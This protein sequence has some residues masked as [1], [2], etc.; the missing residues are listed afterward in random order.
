MLS[1]PCNFQVAKEGYPTVKKYSPIWVPIV[2]FVVVSVDIINNTYH[3]EIIENIA[4]SY[5]DFVRQYH[6]FDGE[7]LKEKNRIRQTIAAQSQPFTVVVEL[8]SGSSH[9]EENVDGRQSYSDLYQSLK[10]KYSTEGHIRQIM[11]TDNIMNSAEGVS[12][13]QPELENEQKCC[14]HSGTVSMSGHPLQRTLWHN[15]TV[16]SNPSSNSNRVKLNRNHHFSRDMI[17]DSYD[18]ITSLYLSYWNTYKK[19][20]NGQRLVVKEC[21]IPN[22]TQ[23]ENTDTTNNRS[24]PNKA[25]NDRI[26]RMMKINDA[27]MNIRSLQERIF[28]LKQERQQG[29]RD[30]DD[31]EMDIREAQ[32]EIIQLQRTHLNWF[33]YF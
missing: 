32:K 24:T 26:H 1:C 12:E 33:Y 16:S 19:V 6:G 5:V 21:H 14:G 9:V 23:H 25:H 28:Q 13:Q 27:K 10:N 11:F 3:R 17:F 20:E 2:V 8:T 29:T 4:P 18:D 22:N 30:M 7:D 15:E 31:I